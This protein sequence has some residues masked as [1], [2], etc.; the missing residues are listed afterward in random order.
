VVASVVE[1]EVDVVG[2]KVGM[3]IDVVEVIGEVVVIAVDV[4]FELAQDTKSKDVIK[5]IV[6][7]TG[8]IPRFM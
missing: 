3:I 7:N 8:I 4:V 6:R 1:R 2:L 5:R